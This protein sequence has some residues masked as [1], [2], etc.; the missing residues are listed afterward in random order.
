VDLI[1]KVIG[2]VVA[3][4]ASVFIS[5]AGNQTANE[6][7]A[8]SPRLV[9][10]LIKRAVS[11]VPE[12]MRDRLY[13]EWHRVIQDTPGQVGQIVQALD[14]LRGAVRIARDHR[15][16]GVRIVVSRAVGVFGVLS[17][18]LLG[19][20]VVGVFIEI[21][22]VSNYA[23]WVVIAAYVIFNW[24][25]A[26]GTNWPGILSLLLLGFAVVGLFTDIPF[27]SNYAFWVV[28]AAY[29]IL[30]WSSAHG[31]NWPGILSLLLL[32]FAVVGVF[33]D[34]PF[35]S[36][37]AF[38]VAIAA[39]IVRDWTFNVLIWTRMLSLLVLGFAV[40][41]VFIEIPF[42]SPYAFWF[43][44]AAY[45]IRFFARDRWLYHSSLDEVTKGA[46]YH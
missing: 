13:E 38:F 19:F 29:V 26:H 1:L 24:S 42:V 25:S 45:N 8:W 36:N 35:V 28:I 27:V 2:F 39:Y 18:L 30:N 44:I 20:A 9:E 14:Y 43:A 4:I 46:S 6:F 3:G 15:R 17:F 5:A 21:P 10:Y 31:T 32:G 34:I 41:G 33:I 11:R 16:V 40:V 12:H 23:F 37:Y 22:F 7:R